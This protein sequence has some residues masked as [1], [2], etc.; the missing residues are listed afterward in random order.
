MDHA[1]RLRARARHEVGLVDEQAVDA[2]ERELAEQPA[3][4]HP[5]PQDQDGDPGLVPEPL[6]RARAVERHSSG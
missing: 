5:A 4:V 6:L 2:L 3:A 1:R